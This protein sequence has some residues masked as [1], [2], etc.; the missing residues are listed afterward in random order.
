MRAGL[1]S[2]A[3]AGIG[4]AA[5]FVC[6]LSVLAHIVYLVSAPRTINTAAATDLLAA[7]AG[8]AVPDA[9]LAPGETCVLVLERAKPGLIWS[10]E[11]SP[12]QT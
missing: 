3:P 12:C 6:L 2:N 9:S 4:E 10:G 8:A 5:G 7:R 11:S 1:E